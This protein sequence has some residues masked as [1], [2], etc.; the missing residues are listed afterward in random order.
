MKDK[1]PHISEHPSFQRRL[2]EFGWMGIRFLLIGLIYFGAARL[3][4]FFVLQPEG[5]AGIWPASGVALASVLLSFRSKHFKIEYWSTL[6]V[7][8]IVNML[9]NYS[10]GNT[11]AISLGFA[12]ANTLE[13]AIGAFVFQQVNNFGKSKNVSPAAPITFDQIRQV[14]ALA[15]AAAATVLPAF[16]GALVPFLGFGASYWDVWSVWWVEDSLGVLL[17]APVVLVL[18]I[19][20]R[21]FQARPTQWWVELVLL[22]LVTGLVSW[23]SFGGY[24]NTHP[25]SLRPY[26]GFVFIFWAAMR[27][28][29]RVMSVEL[30]LLAGIALGI[31]AAGLGSFPLGGDTAREHLVF[32]QVYLFI[33]SLTGFVLVAIF[34]E[35]RQAAE[36]LRERNY[37][38]ETILE[39]A[40]IGFAVNRIS[41][42]Q[43]TF[44][45]S[46]FDTLYG[47]PV[48]G[49][50][51]VDE[52]F[53]KVYLD[54]VFRA[55]MRE[56]VMADIASGDPARMH[57][58]N[59]PITTLAGEHRVITATN[60]PVLEQDLMI[61]TVQ[62]VTEHWR[63]EEILRVQSTA[64][65]SA[66]NAIIITDKEGCIEWVNQAFSILTGYEPGEAIGK[67]P[68][69]LVKSGRHEPAFYQDLWDTIL[70]GKSWKGEMFNRRKDGQIYTEEQTITPVLNASGQ[71]IQFIAIKQDITERKQAEK[72]LRESNEALEVAYSATLQGWSNALELRER[73]TAGHSQRV[74]ELTLALAQAM[75]GSQA[76]LEHIYHGALLHD[77]GKMGIPDHILLKPGPLND[78][79]WKVMRMH[80][81]Y[82]FNLLAKIPYLSSALDIPYHHHERWDGSGY[83]DGLAGE[84]IPLSARIF[85][86]VDVWDALASDRPYRQAWQR[87]SICEYL[88]EQAGRQFDPKVV[89][90]FLNLMQAR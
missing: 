64:L 10:A 22:I 89:N 35:R 71:V 18:F 76:E 29:A 69:D 68:R 58:E 52:H 55:Q 4:L 47:V 7:I 65:K 23:L 88:K 53:E 83:P 2:S 66:A 87:E 32:V 16:I 33:S 12:F 21:I 11:L 24:D 45:S 38:I 57:W 82:A 77:I 25:L 31:T 37:F 43:A 46:K 60:I 81:L 27:F 19:N 8:F 20:R 40:P 51:S 84:A 48:G 5:L 73:E 79:E 17:F 1:K 72:L 39:N 28:S 90:A 3:G 26:M 80:P 85:A 86:V 74:V 41:D 59:I 13:P 70:A 75:G 9:S 14:L 30:I 44:I 15:A 6:A 78:E 62:D 63:A 54:P 42:G 56:R 49:I 50:T 67:N 36:A 61:S 34:T